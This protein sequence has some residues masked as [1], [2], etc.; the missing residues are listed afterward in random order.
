MRKGRAPIAPI[1]YQFRTIAFR[2][3]KYL[4]SNNLGTSAPPDL[5]IQGPVLV[6]CGGSPDQFPSDQ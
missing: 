3:C 4:C 6:L 2:V 1:V 5:K